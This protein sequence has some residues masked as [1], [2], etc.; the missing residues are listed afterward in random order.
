MFR[1]SDASGDSY[2]LCWLTASYP[3]LS[4]NQKQIFICALGR[5]CSRPPRAV[6][7][8]LLSKG[9]GGDFPGL[10]RL[11][12]H[13]VDRAVGLPRLAPLLAV[14]AERHYSVAIVALDLL[15]KR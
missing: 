8:L 7:L 5:K 3:I 12:P 9:E 2:R 10:V 4:P 14:P 6:T 11:H 15:A 13:H 1:S